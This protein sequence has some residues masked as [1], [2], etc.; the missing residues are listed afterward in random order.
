MFDEYNIM[1]LERENIHIVLDDFIDD[2][3]DE[4]I[5]QTIVD[6]PIVQTIV[7]E[8][9]VQTIVDEPI[10]Q[11]IVDEPI[12]QTIVDEPTIVQT[13]V[14]EPIVQTI[15]DEPTIVQT[16]VDEPI[17]QTIVDEP[18]VQTIVDEPIVQTIVDEPIVQTI[19]D[20]PIVQT[21]VDEPTIDLVI[22]DDPII[23][24]IPEIIFVIPYRDRKEEKQY[25]LNKIDTILTKD[26]Q[27]KS[28]IFFIEQND[29]RSFNRGAMKNIGF[30]AIK[31]LYPDNYKNITIVFND[32]DTM[33][34]EP[35]LLN[36][37]TTIGRIKH[38]YGYTFAL[39]GIV[40]ITGQ[41]FE[42]L[43]G[44]PNYWAWGFEDNLLNKRAVKAGIYIDRTQFYPI[45]D[46]K[47]TQFIGSPLKQVNR[48]EF[49]RYIQQIHE[50][51]QSITH[52]EYSPPIDGRIMSI[53]VNQFSTGYNENINKRTT[54]DLRNGPV[55]FRSGFSGR[56]RASIGMVI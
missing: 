4:P 22:I 38:F 48:G 7:D 30:L 27:S 1:N 17:V 33:P 50:G 52:L 16:I 8:S 21:I 51:I 11:T 36:Y 37:S 3:I 5:V 39:G 29:T 49:D 55:P 54:H 14:D 41:D 18:I 43:N 19:V 46:P 24:T 42:T 31:E 26:Q 15:V 25:F 35:G 23:D 9:I 45:H 34:A 2:F 53:G 47:I 40:S 20:E 56:R 32:I 28:K 44:F 10:V 13:I 6:E 12:V